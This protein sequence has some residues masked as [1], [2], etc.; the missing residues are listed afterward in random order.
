MKAERQSRTFCQ[1]LWTNWPAI[2]K[3][4]PEVGFPQN[5]LKKK[6]KKSGAGKR[7]ENGELS[8]ITSHKRN[9]AQ[10]REIFKRQGNRSWEVSVWEI[11]DQGIRLP[12]SLAR[13]VVYLCPLPRPPASITFIESCHANAERWYRQKMRRAKREANQQVAARR[14]T[15]IIPHIIHNLE[16]HAIRKAAKRDAD[17]SRLNSN[18]QTDTDKEKEAMNH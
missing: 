12:R 18:N 13:L 6:E 8:A 4:R 17:W 11:W 10:K 14:H 15:W 3:L 5:I 7:E 16:K 9:A 1:Q 2:Q